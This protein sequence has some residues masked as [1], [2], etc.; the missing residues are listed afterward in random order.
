[1]AEIYFEV[2]RHLFIFLQLLVAS[3]WYCLKE[4][5]KK[6]HRLEEALKIQS[7]EPQKKP[8]EPLKQVVTP[9]KTISG[10]AKTA[11]TESYS[12]S[13]SQVVTP[14]KPSNDK[15]PT[16]GNKEVTKSKAPI[17]NKGKINSSDQ[18]ICVIE[19]DDDDDEDDK[20]DK[21]ASKKENKIETT[22]SK[23]KETETT[24]VKIPEPTKG[25]VQN[26]KAARGPG[27]PPK[28]LPAPVKSK[29]DLDK[30]VEKE[31]PKKVTKHVEETII[32]DEDDDIVE[33]DTSSHG[34][35]SDHEMFD[36]DCDEIQDETVKKGSVT[37]TPYK[38]IEPSEK[39]KASSI[40]EEAEPKESEEK[41]KEET[42]KSP[43]TRSKA[44]LDK[45][46]KQNDK[47]NAKDSKK[48]ED[49][50]E[51]IN[52]IFEESDEEEATEAGDSKTVKE[53]TPD[54][55]SENTENDKTEKDKE[56]EEQAPFPMTLTQNIA[57]QSDTA[58]VETSQSQINQID[59]NNTQ[60]FTT[61]TPDQYT[62]LTEA[63]ENSSVVNV[64]GTANGQFIDPSANVMENIVDSRQHYIQQ[65]GIP[66][67]VKQETEVDVDQ[68]V[69][70]MSSAPVQGLMPVQGMHGMVAHQDMQVL[71]P[72]LAAGQTIQGM[73]PPQGMHPSGIPGMDPLQRL[74]G[75]VPPGQG[76]GPHPPPGFMYNPAVHHQGPAGFVDPQFQRQQFLPPNSNP[77]SLSS[78]T[79]G[80]L[81]YP[82]S[83]TES[84]PALY[85]QPGMMPGL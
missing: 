80:A 76:M 74:Q 50:I 16:K 36:M 72:H 35:T 77:V 68:A 64:S 70:R 32:L 31:K 66:T 45:G 44:K 49:Q 20:K 15:T 9:S 3:V 55:K 37:K 1:M 26:Q 17:V 53:T 33:Q 82:Y 63:S 7:N 21:P 38:I 14:S 48:S 78:L 34:N 54:K 12:V 62:Q 22:P 75:M 41:E 52:V 6:V 79:S 57:G 84:T 71:P 11:L 10:T 2:Y 67:V 4:E 46:N 40:V 24:K 81:T 51:N 65:P 25:I 5:Q 56:N 23:K 30:Q 73:L 43:R 58:V 42:Q 69:H 83:S 8:S 28:T 29:K 59:S 39:A 47:K 13:K 61:I 19:I 85:R 60:E 27:R 18:D